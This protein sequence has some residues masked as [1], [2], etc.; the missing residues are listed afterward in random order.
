M[1]YLRTMISIAMVLMLI[2]GTAEGH[3]D[4]QTHRY[5]WNL[6][7]HHEGFLYNAAS[8]TEGG[9]GTADDP[10]YF[11]IAPH[12]HVNIAELEAELGRPAFGPPELTPREGALLT[13]P[14]TTNNQPDMDNGGQM[15]DD[16]EPGA[17]YTPV[18]EMQPQVSGIPMAKPVLGKRGYMP[19]KIKITHVR[20][21]DNIKYVWLIYV[22]NESGRNVG[23]GSFMLEVWDKEQLGMEASKPRFSV[24]LPRD[25]HFWYGGVP[26]NYKEF[27]NEEGVRANSCFLLVDGYKFNFGDWDHRTHP[28][29]FYSKVAKKYAKLYQDSDV[30][31]IRHRMRKTI[32]TRYPMPEADPEPA[33]A[34]MRI[35]PGK[36]VSLWASQK[37]QF[38]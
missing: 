26:K 23:A 31:L 22:L 38:K 3:S 16:S 1:F 34:P 25:A 18:D 32:I 37:G 14:S 21:V 13:N 35:T 11:D 29:Q 20:K 9:K 24:S 12:S 30:F 17:S 7:H 28:V 33:A 2:Q 5:Y 8:Y 6:N 19:P 15:T 27:T 36:L 10:R 4:E